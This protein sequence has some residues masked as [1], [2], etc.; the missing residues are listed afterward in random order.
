MIGHGSND[1]ALK[2]RLNIINSAESD[3]NY[4]MWKF[5]PDSVGTQTTNALAAAAKRGVKVNVLVDGNV[6]SRDPKEKALLEKIR[7]AGVNVVESK[8]SQIEDAMN[9]MHAKMILVDCSAEALAKGLTPTRLATDRNDG[10]QYLTGVA[11]KD[12][13]GHGWSGSDMV[14]KGAGAAQGMK[15]FTDL[16]NH[17]APEGQKLAA[18]SIPSDA[19]LKKLN[20]GKN[21]EGEVM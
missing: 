16:F 3:I 10:E 1:A 17:W 18:S 2:A 5:Y 13:T 4:A 20:E 21:L 15:A 9:G 7:A 6:S 19:D 14:F 11:G 8:N 12:D